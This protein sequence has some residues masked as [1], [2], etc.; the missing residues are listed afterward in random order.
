MSNTA[1]EFAEDVTGDD[2]DVTGPIPVDVVGAVRV[3]EFPA[4]TI[5]TGQ[6]PVGAQAV[7]VVSALRSRVRVHLAVPAGSGPLWIG[8][9]AGITAGA[10]FP[11]V[12]GDPPLI[13]ETSADVFA[14]APAGNTILCWLTQNR[15][16]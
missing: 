14:V 6:V 15:D 10:G 1:S 5:N 4:R 2:P 16:G 3:Q 7:R 8:G 12:A 13:L 9:H 11:L